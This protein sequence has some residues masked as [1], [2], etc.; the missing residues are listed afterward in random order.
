[1]DNTANYLSILKESL[2]K[3]IT[4]L[5]KIIRLNDL[6][7]ESVS[8]DKIDEEKFEKAIEEKEVCIEEL[9][10]LDNGFEAVYKHIQKI[11][12]DNPGMYKKEIEEFKKLISTIT[13][14]SME[15]QI[16]EKRNESLVM[17]K[18][19]EERTKIRRSK[20]A[21]KV[22]SDYYKNMSGVSVVEP[23]FMDKKK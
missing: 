13:E 15:I 6:Q 12:T 5:D 14:K 8:Q 4:I 9:T 17:K 19:S 11:I 16:S 18:L 3:K 10:K 23:Q 21:N 7:K 1:M 2:D 20:T 22:A